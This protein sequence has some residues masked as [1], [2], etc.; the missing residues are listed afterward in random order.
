MAARYVSITLKEFETFMNDMNYE[1]VESQHGEYVFDR[2]FQRVKAFVRVYSSISQSGH[3]RKKGGDAIRVVVFY[4]REGRWAPIKK[5]K[6]VHRVANWRA[7]LE[8]R[9]EEA[10]LN[11]CADPCPRCDAPMLLREGKHGQFYSCSA[12]PTTGCKGSAQAES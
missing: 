4:D 12:W 7:N 11:V 3:A 10:R 9:I 8:S 6:R 1:R 5:Q 2:K